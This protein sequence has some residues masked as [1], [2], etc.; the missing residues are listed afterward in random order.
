[1]NETNT[2][3]FQNKLIPKQ[4]LLISTNCSSHIPKKIYGITLPENQRFECSPNLS[5]SQMFAEDIICIYHSSDKVISDDL[6][7]NNFSNS[8]EG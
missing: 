7:R 3:K 4:T 8:V 1:M 2:N 5:M 6:G